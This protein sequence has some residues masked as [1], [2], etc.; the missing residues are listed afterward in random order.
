[1]KKKKN[2]L[3]CLTVFGAHVSVIVL[4]LRDSEVSIQ[5]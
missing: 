4:V 1:V 5:N 2:M 3:G